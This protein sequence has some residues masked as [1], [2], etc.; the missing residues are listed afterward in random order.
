MFPFDDVIMVCTDYRGLNPSTGFTASRLM[1][2][3]EIHKS[4]DVQFSIVTDGFEN[5]GAYVRKL[6]E[7]RREAHRI[8][9]N[10]LETLLIK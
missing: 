9:R 1:L 10:K 8:A 4:I 7:I 3:Q 2:A 6:D 5:A